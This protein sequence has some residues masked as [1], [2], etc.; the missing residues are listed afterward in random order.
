MH[1]ADENDSVVNVKV[2]IENVDVD[3]GLEIVCEGIVVGLTRIVV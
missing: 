1:T 2:A 3:I